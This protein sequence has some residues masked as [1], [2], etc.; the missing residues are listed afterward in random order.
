VK[1]VLSRAAVAVVLLLSAIAVARAQQPATQAPAALPALGRVRPIAPPATPLA[2]EAESAAIT[3][4]SFIAY[5]DTRSSGQPNVPGDG[6]IVQ[7]DHSRIVDRIIVKARELARTPFPVRFVVQSGDAVLRGQDAAMW[8]VSFS[9]LVERLTKANMPYFFSVG[10]HDVTNGPS[11]DP[12][13]SLGLH[14]T[15]AA[16]SNLMPREGSAHRLSGYPTYAFGYGNSFFIAFDSN[17][18]TDAVQLA[19]VTD[20]LEHLDRARYRHVVA[21]FHHPP[22]SSGPHSGASATAV[23]GTGQ[24]APDRVEPQTAALRSLYLPVFRKH[25]VSMMI[26]GHDHFFDHFVE[27][28][29]DGGVTYRMDTVVTGGGGAPIYP[30]VGEPDLRGYEMANAAQQVRVE[31]LMKPGT[32]VENPNHFVVVQ[33]DGSRLSLEVVGVGPSEYRPYKGGAKMVLSDAAR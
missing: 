32:V 6:D 31:H 25:H 8:N 17:I 26:V 15:L 23:S 19:W 30:Y 20:Q 10:N 3:R 33:V 4:F 12:D 24:K 9:P 29:V 21:I 11:G 28:Y 13:R 1:N 22:F 16:M 27:H 7:R 2:G 18:P 5:G 14:N